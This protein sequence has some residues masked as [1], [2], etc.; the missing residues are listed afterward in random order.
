MVTSESLTVR[1]IPGLGFCALTGL[2]FV[3]VLQMD[4]AVELKPLV[5]YRLSRVLG[6]ACRE[7]GHQDSG[8]ASLLLLLLLPSVADWATWN[9]QLL[10]K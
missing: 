7:A 5:V 4:L 10:Q 8:C 6:E 9:C 1:L 2:A 3:L